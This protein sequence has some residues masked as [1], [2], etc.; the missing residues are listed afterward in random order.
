M[1]LEQT[2]IIVKPDGLVKSLTG[3]ILSRLSEAKLVI[4]G[5]RVV[6]VSRELAVQHYEHLQD[7]PFFEEL[8]DYIMGKQHNSYRVAAFVYRGEDAI[9]KI[10]DIVGDTDPE[11]A[12][13]VSIRGAYGTDH[14]E[15]CL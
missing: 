9:K 5:A 13:P 8:I 6:R 3:N 12:N 4:V 7:K 15:R 2:L 1:A 10:R 11:K 14:Q